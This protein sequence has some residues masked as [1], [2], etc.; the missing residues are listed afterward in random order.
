MVN[1]T[2]FSEFLDVYIQEA[3]EQIEKLDDGLLRLE[4]EPSDTD[5]LNAIFRAAHTLKGSSATMGFTHIKDLTHDAE[6]L[7]DA[8]RSGPRP[9]ARPWTVSWRRP[10]S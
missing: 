8:L 9:E 5:I 10:P 4:K 6:N 2:D 3:N 7:L 1:E